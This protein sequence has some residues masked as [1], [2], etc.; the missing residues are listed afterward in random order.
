MNQRTRIETENKRL[1]DIAYKID[2]KTYRANKGR[3]PPPRLKHIDVVADDRKGLIQPTDERHEYK[4]SKDFINNLPFNISD[5][6]NIFNLIKS[7]FKT[8]SSCLIWKYHRNYIRIP[9]THTTKLPSRIII[10]IPQYNK[11]IFCTHN[12]I[13]IISFRRL[14]AEGIRALYNIK[15]DV[16]ADQINDVCKHTLNIDNIFDNVN[17][18]ITKYIISGSN[19]YQREQRLWY[20]C[21]FM[22]KGKVPSYLND[23]SIKKRCQSLLPL[24]KNYQNREDVMNNIIDMLFN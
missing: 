17:T 3:G 10:N 2:I 24:H 20:M 19:E 7:K 11:L 5:V 15:F 14:A 16:D 23:E 4:E 6:P 18:R 1:Q 8:R 9:R 22:I 21:W 13:Y 12:K